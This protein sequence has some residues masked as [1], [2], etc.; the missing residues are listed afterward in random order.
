MRHLL[1]LDNVRYRKFKPVTDLE[2]KPGIHQDY[3]PACSPNLNLTERL[4]KF[5]KTGLR[6]DFS[7][8]SSPVKHITDEITDSAYG[9]NKEHIDRL[10]T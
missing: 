7:N 6:T 1:I 8:C 10:I 9:E 4:W 5:V 3:S 2:E